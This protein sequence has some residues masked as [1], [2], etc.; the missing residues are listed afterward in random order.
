M[1]KGDMTAGDIAAMKERKK[2][3]N[4]KLKQDLAKEQVEMGRSTLTNR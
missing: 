2:K 1:M 3:L 4:A